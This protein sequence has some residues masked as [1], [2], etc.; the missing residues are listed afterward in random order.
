MRALVFALH[1]LAREPGINDLPRKNFVVTPAAA[2]VERGIDLGF[3]QRG[4]Q[5]AF[6]TRGGFNDARDASI[7][8]REQS[9]F[10]SDAR[11]HGPDFD[12]G[13]ARQ[14]L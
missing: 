12:I 11:R 9:L 13:N 3:A 2:G 14:I 8:G 7:A 4:I 5:I 1:E 6:Q 10:V